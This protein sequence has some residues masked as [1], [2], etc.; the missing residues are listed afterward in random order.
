MSEWD[1]DLPF[2]PVPMWVAELPISDRA[3]R[4]YTLLS[5]MRDYGTGR[6][7]YGRKLLAKKLRCSDDSLDRAKKELEDHGAITIERGVAN[8][9]AIPRNIYMVH[10]IPPAN[11]MGAGTPIAAPERVADSRTGAAMNENLLDEKSP[12]SPGRDPRTIGKVRVTDAEHDQVDTLLGLFNELAG[13]KRFAGKSW[14]ESIIRRLR[15]HPELPLD[16]HEALVRFQFEHPWWK[17]DPTPNVIWGNDRVFDRTLNRSA[18][19][20]GRQNEA[21]EYTRPE[22]D[23]YGDESS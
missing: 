9:G 7:S 13:G 21:S 18:S 20:P 8:G 15:D 16:E 4:L 2:A 23:Q 10:R 1:T 22:N 5:G 19:D 3:L 11:R 14:R 12:S 6:A 17:D